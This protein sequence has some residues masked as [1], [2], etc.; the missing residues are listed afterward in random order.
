MELVND[1]FDN[2]NNANSRASS[3]KCHLYTTFKVSETRS[4]EM[5]FLSLSAKHFLNFRTLNKM[6]SPKLCILTL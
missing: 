3:Q 2:S 4:N 5:K 6:Y 1:T